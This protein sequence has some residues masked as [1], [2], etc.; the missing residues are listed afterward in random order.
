VAFVC[1]ALLS[2]AW[3]SQR[4]RAQRALEA[5]VL[6]RTADL[7]RSNTALQ[8]EIVEREAAE[9]ELRH[10]ET[11]LAQGQKLSRTASWLLH[12]PEGD[13]QWSAH[14]FDILGLDRVSA[15][16]SYRLFTERM[17]PDDRPRFAQA[18]E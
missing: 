18:V 4:R 3:S 12:L 10:S 7:L 2:L 8:A 6:Q 14:F 11:L 13:M 9:E 15:T 5:T 16:P 17:H 1:F